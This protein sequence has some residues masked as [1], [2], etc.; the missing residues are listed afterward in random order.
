MNKN[1]K[2]PQLKWFELDSTEFKM[3]QY[4]REFRD[5]DRFD[6]WVNTNSISHTLYKLLNNYK[7]QQVQDTIEYPLLRQF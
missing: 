4:A 5:R 7:N 2:L 3:Q 1:K 6:E